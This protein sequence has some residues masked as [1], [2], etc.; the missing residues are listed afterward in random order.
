MVATGQ[1]GAV[2]SAPPGPAV[3]IGDKPEKWPLESGPENGYH[4][5][6]Y[7]LDPKGVPTFMYEASGVRIAER[8]EPG[9]D[10]LVRR[11]FEVR[12]LPSGQTAWIAIGPKAAAIIEGQGSAEILTIGSTPCIALT[13]D[14]AAVVNVSK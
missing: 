4:F 2:W 7:R 6:G 3:V 5:K 12:G 8:F 1:G 9:G 13:S 10:S 14:G 11:R